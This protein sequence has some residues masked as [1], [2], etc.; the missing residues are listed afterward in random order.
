MLGKS[1][2]EKFII[3]RKVYFV[4]LCNEI[5]NQTAISQG[6]GLQLNVMK[7]FPIFGVVLKQNE[8]P[9]E[10]ELSDTNC[11]QAKAE[12]PFSRISTETIQTLTRR[13]D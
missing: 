6:N 13:L 11:T 9:H 1:M 4:F 3:W 10:S 8:S 2:G 5:Q 7:S 12:G